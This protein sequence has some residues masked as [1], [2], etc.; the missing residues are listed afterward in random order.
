MLVATSGHID[1]GKTALV[2]AL[3]GVET[4]RL[5]EERARGI[6]IDLGFA[7]W[8]PEPGLTIGFIDVPGHERFVRNMLA[9]VSAVDFALL[10]VAADDGVMP[11]TIEHLE[12]LDLLGISRGVVAITKCDRAAP[13]R[14]A[15]VAADI[16][17]LLADTSLAQAP[18]VEICALDGRGI[19]ALSA[20]LLEAAKAD[21][22]GGPNDRQFRLAIDRAFSVTGAGTVVTGTIVDG[23]VKVGDRLAVATAGLE[24]RVRG[25]QSGGLSVETAGAGER[26]AVNIAGIDVASVHRGDWLCGQGMGRPTSRIEARVGILASAANPLRHNAPLHLHLGTADLIARALI[27]GQR[28]IPP[29]GEALVHLVLDTPATCCTG[30]R[31]VLREASGRRTIGGGRVIDPFAPDSRRKDASRHAVSAALEL[32]GPAAALA[33]LRTIPGHEIDLDHFAACFNL[34]VEAARRLCDAH[35]WTV[36][37]GGRLLALPQERIEAARHQLTGLLATLHREQPD[38]AGL[39]ARDLRKALQPPPSGQAFQL[40]LKDMLAGG[41]I[42]ASGAL[43]RLA[44]HTAVFSPADRAM[45][46]QVVPWLEERAPHPFTVAELVAELRTGEAAVKAMLF[47][48]VHNGD[49]W[50]VTDK[51][52]MLAG[53]V[54]HLADAAV[55]LAASTAPAGFTAAQFR[56]ATGLGRTFII[57]LLEFFDSIG[58]TAR[59]G[60]ERT[61]RPDYAATVGEAAPLDPTSG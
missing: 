4:D 40:L 14:I 9:G 17:A 24:T 49:V 5:P 61:M 35:G 16:R 54:R 37:K 55:A 30:D 20:M 52:Y 31:L 42:E 33:G 7:Y 57:Q 32:G 1:H 38:M 2:R 28:E 44:G 45:W 47:R 19:A 34:G 21:E 26:C 27:R 43:Y 22:R 51:R 41:E 48:R 39:C 6:S 59:R 11:Q 46:Q 53:H 8:R 25:L 56:D 29:G 13:E 18:I 12:I 58:V 23:G 3:T 10:V 36:L 50:R 60:D 15:E